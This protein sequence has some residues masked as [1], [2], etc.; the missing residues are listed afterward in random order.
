MGVAITDLL[1]GKPILLKDLR[2]KVIAIDAFNMLYQFLT[3]LR[4]PDGGPLINSKGQITSH[5]QGLL[6]RNLQF[7]K[8]GVKPIYVFDGIPPPQKKEERERRKKV[9]EEA[10]VEYEIAKER[11]DFEAMRKYASRMTY[12]SDDIISSAKQLLTYLGIPYVDAKGEGEA[13]AAY[14]VQKGDA[15]YV[16]SEDADAFLFGAP[17]VI[18]HLSSGKNPIVYTLSDIL[19]TLGIDRPKLIALGMLVGTDYNK[20]GIHGIGPKKGLIVVK[21]ATSIQDIFSSVGFSEW[22]T[23]YDIFMSAP[24]TDEYA[25][26]WGDIKKEV[27]ITWL[28]ESYDFSEQRLEKIFSGLDAVLSEKK[29][30]GLN[31]FF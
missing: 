19:N 21:S 27:I 9:K 20:G 12:V 2:G 25:L 31:D 3:V 8:N 1:Q 11:N 7:L 28:S 22:K 18:R 15:E 5:L 4:G 24:T 30:K 14:M 10:K 23:I 26:S 17:R 29:Q 13:Q 16:V 6:S